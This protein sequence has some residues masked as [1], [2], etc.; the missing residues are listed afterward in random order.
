M[1]DKLRVRHKVTNKPVLKTVLI[2]S[3]AGIALAAIVGVIVFFA[4][5]LGR[6]EKALAAA[7]FNSSNNGTW[8]SGSSW[9]GTAP[10][11]STSQDTHFT[12]SHYITRNG[13]LSFAKT[14]SLNIN[15]GAT[16]EVMGSFSIQKDMSMVI[17]GDLIIW[18]PL[19]VAKDAILTVNGNGNITVYGPATLGKETTFMINGVVDFKDDLTLDKSAQVTLNSG[20]ELNVGGN[21]SF[22]QDAVITNNG[23]INVNQDLTFSQPPSQFD[24]SGIVNLGG[25]GCSYWSGAGTCAENTT[26]PVQLLEFSA[27]ADND[28]VIIN[29]R[30]ATE[31]NNDYFT[32]ERSGDGREFE[33]IG[34]VTGNGTTNNVSV[35]EYVDERPLY[36]TSYYRLKQTD[37]D[38]ASETFRAVY[39]ESVFEDQPKASAYPNPFTGRELHLKLDKPVEGIVE[40]FD[41]NGTVVYTKNL[42]GFDSDIS[43]VMNNDLPTGIYLLTI[44]SGTLNQSIKIVRR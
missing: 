3:A 10:P 1:N 18:G 8:I 26:L 44:K 6:N 35:Y 32:I 22:G 43:M 2:V 11:T 21:L 5:N 12:I 42:D 16:L 23:T 39:V 28:Q 36:G 4:L 14:N 33:P 25:T 19:D 30:T 37:F 17:D 27:I 20:G 31:S 41:Q 38:D 24:G 34:E 40:M 15:S 29:W 7:Y 9:G 13:D